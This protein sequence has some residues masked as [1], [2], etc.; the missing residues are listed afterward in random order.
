MTQGQSRIAPSGHTSDRY[1]IRREVNEIVKSITDLREWEILQTELKDL[2]EMRLQRDGPLST[3]LLAGFM[4]SSDHERAVLLNEQ[5]DAPNAPKK[6]RQVFEPNHDLLKNINATLSRAKAAEALG[7]SP[8]NFDRLK[9]TKKI[10]PV[11]PTSRKRYR[12]RDLLLLAD[13]KL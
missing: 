8:R 5:E 7:M 2:A 9:K 4:E 10:L 6:R 11:G 12:V 1:S 3:T 13:R